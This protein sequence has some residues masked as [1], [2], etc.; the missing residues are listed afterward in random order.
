MKQLKRRLQYKSSTMSLNIRP[1]KVFQVAR[2]LAT[3]S[4]LYR[5]QGIV[6]DEHWHKNFQGNFYVSDK[7]MGH[8]YT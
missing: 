7:R 2:W 4:A 6:F 5:E 8:E 1:H 3:N